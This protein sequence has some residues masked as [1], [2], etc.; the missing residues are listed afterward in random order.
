MLFDQE[1]DNS[2]ALSCWKRKSSSRGRDLGLFVEDLGFSARVGFL[3]FRV[4]GRAERE[5]G[6]GLMGNWRGID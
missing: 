6:F 5:E 2:K 4:D 1:R 3:W